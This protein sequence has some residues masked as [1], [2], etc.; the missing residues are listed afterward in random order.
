MDKRKL[1][2]DRKLSKVPAGGLWLR[3]L[4][5]AILVVSIC[6]LAGA[7]PA[8]ADGQCT[9]TARAALRACGNELE[10][11]YWIAIGK[12]NNLSDSDARDACS[13]EARD[14]R[15]EAKE[16]CRAQF[17]ARLELCD[18]LGEAPYDPEIDPDRFVDPSAI[19]DSVTPNPYFP[20]I[21]GRTW[22]YQGG[23]ETNTV[24]VTAETKE[25]LGV[26]CAVVHDVVEDDGEVIEDTVDW[27][28]QDVDGNVWYFGEIAQEFEDGDL[29][30]LA[31]SWK[32]GVDGARAGIVMLA[33]PEV[34]DLYR[35]EFL[36]GEA[37]DVAEVLSLTGS[38]VVPA[39][40]CDGNCLITR[41]FT[42]IEPDVVEHKYYA[43]GV[44]LILEVNS[45]TGERVELVEI[46][47]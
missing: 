11:D 6:L 37:E 8:K 21:P 14:L 24:T 4:R 5:S 20:L 27:F 43:P 46:E 18:T 45:E 15:K 28:A 38:E 33:D 30:S 32:A 16:E 7:Q 41:D 1:L 22:T 13:Q 42:P 47:N 34:G 25:I 31:G 2:E 23:T 39:A 10:A 35:Q 29:V 17:E 19:G 26:T 9:N 36:L 44:G 12:C 3:L 40:T